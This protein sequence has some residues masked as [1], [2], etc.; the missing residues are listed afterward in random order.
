M[1][2]A[3]E[4][5]R[6]ER[7]AR[8][9]FDQLRR[10][11]KRSFRMNMFAQPAEQRGEFAP[12]YRRQHVRDGFASGFEQLRCDQ[13]AESVGREITPDSIIPVDVLQ[14]PLAVVG[15][16]LCRAIAAAPRPRRREDPPAR[17]RRRSSPAQDDSAK[18]REQDTSL[19]RRRPVSSRA[20]HGSGADG[21]LRRPP[22]PVAGKH[23][24]QDWRRE[25]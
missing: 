1:Q 2:M 17:A 18:S 6:P 19:R 15:R 21:V 9:A 11:Q 10:R 3:F 5:R 16:G 24:A 20:G 4:T 13:R 23:L 14:T 7:P 25:G 8:D 12:L 22:R